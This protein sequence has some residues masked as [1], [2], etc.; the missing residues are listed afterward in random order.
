M[1]MDLL[2]GEARR[3]ALREAIQSNDAAT[4]EN[5]LTVSSADYY[6]SPGERKLHDAREFAEQ[7]LAVSARLLVT[8]HEKGLLT[9]DEVEA[10]IT[11]L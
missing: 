5:Y 3:R 6:A 8:L 4:V 11:G 2:T 1:R 7:S 9:S 10:V